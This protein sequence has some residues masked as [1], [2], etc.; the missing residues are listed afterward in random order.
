MWLKQKAVIQNL[1]HCLIHNAVILTK[2]ARLGKD[3][4]QFR[5]IAKFIL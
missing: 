2:G 4:S 1:I 3:L 5:N